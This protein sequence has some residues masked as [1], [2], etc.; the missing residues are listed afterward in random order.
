M[1]AGHAVVAL[2]ISLCLMLLAGSGLLVRT[3]RNLESADL[4]LNASGLVV[5]GTTPPQQPVHESASKPDPNVDRFAAPTPEDLAA[6]RFYS[7]LLDRL[8]LHDWTA[9]GSSRGAVDFLPSGGVTGNLADFWI[10]VGAGVL[11]V[12]WIGRRL[13]RPSVAADAPNG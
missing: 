7:N 6:I 10:A 12:A 3:L 8:K 1:R 4:G 2:Q 13:A 5:F 9:P 11:V